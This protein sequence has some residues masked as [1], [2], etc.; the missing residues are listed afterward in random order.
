MEKLGAGVEGVGGVGG[1]DRTIRRQQAWPA[2]REVGSLAWEDKNGV[3]Q[4]LTVNLSAEPNGSPEETRRVRE[5]SGLPHHYGPYGDRVTSS[6]FDFS[7]RVVR[8]SNRQ[9]FEVVEEAGV[10]KLVGRPAV[11]DKRDLKTG[12][13]SICFSFF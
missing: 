4:I 11:E 2:E 6:S 5:K 13:T 12:A 1:W 3:A 8:H 10:V 9:I 7:Q